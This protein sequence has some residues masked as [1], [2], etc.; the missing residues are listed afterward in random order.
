MRF[1]PDAA[2][3]PGGLRGEGFFLRPLRAADCD[4]DFDAVVSSADLLLVKSLGRWPRPGFT[5]QENLADLQAHEADHLARRAFTFTVLNH[6]E[7]ECLGCVYLNP[8]H[9]TLA[10]Y[11]AGE[12]E[13]ATVGDDETSVHFWVRQSRLVGGLDGRLFAALRWW[14]A[15]DWRYARVLY[16]AN[17]DEARQV[18]LYAEAGLR[19]AYALV[20]PNDG[21]VM[22]FFG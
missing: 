5:W 13:L 17:D 19:P 3:V 10:G 1:Y 20:T 12:A 6:A 15:T 4:L 9:A 8:L 7:S 14:L 2:P 11:G 18:Q 16:R 21:P 22:R